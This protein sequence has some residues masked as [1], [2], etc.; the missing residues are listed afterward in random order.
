MNKLYK[1][2]IHV[3]PNFRLPISSENERRSLCH[4]NSARVDDPGVECVNEADA[5]DD[6]HAEEQPDVTPDL[7][8]EVRQSVVPDY[9]PH[10]ERGREIQLMIN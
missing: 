3:L 7:G 2:P 6:G 10:L 5:V 9:A 1:T 8:V 4:L